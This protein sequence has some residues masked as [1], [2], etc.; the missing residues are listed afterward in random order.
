MIGT[1]QQVLRSD[2]ESTYTESTY[3][4]ST[5]TR[6][7]TFNS[8]APPFHALRNSCSTNQASEL[9]PVP[10]APDVDRTTTADSEGSGPGHRGTPAPRLSHPHS[11]TRLHRAIPARERTNP[12][13]RR[14]SAHP[15]PRPRLAG[16]S[17]ACAKLKA[18][19]ADACAEPPSCSI[20]TLA[21]HGGTGN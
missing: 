7:S 11:S 19:L 20:P 6:S 3:T 16:S 15:A 4:E 21:A 5:Y 14:T 8:S 18:E 10:S 12:E 13:V 2:K 9:R 1:D 17:G